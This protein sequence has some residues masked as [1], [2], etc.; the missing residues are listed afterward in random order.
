MTHLSEFFSK[1]YNSAIFKPQILMVQIMEMV[2]I[3]D[4]TEIGM[5]QIVTIVLIQLIY[6][7]YPNKMT[8]VA[9]RLSKPPI[10]TVSTKGTV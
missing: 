5:R 2:P 3:M 10:V 8:R 4:I 7:I 9:M 6:V 1:M